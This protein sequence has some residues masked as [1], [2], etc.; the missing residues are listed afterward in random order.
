MR[1]DATYTASQA[2]T[3]GR[4]RQS[5]A[6][7]EQELHDI[8][9][10]HPQCTLNDAEE[11]VIP[12]DAL[13]DVLR[14][15]SS[16]HNSVEL[17]DKAEEE[18]LTAI[19][20]S[21]PGLQ[22]TPQILLQFIATKTGDS[23]AFTSSSS[24]NDSPSESALDTDEDERGRQ[25]ERD[26]EGMNSRSSSR[27]STATYYRSSSR[28]PK[29]PRD[30][31]F[32]T[33]RRQ[34]TTPLGKKETAPSSWSRRPAPPSR[35]KSD[36]SQGHGRA[37]SDSESISSPPPHQTPG[38]TRAPSNPT[39]PTFTS[40]QLSNSI[41]SPTFSATH[42][43]P[44]S[45]AQSQP[46]NT[47]TSFDHSFGY[48]SSPERDTG[49]TGLM[50]PP[51]SA[52]DSF[53]DD[54]SFEDQ[55]SSLQMPKRDD[56]DDDDEDDDDEINAHLL[57]LIMDRSAASSTASLDV[58]ERMEA[59]Q[60]LN[61]D[62]GRKLLEG[63]RT[64]QTR[65]SDHETELEEMQGRIEELRAELSATKRE[66]KELRS[67]ERQNATQIV[68][69][70]VEL[71]RTQKNL[72]QTRATFN[73]VQKQYSEQCAESERIRNQ[74]RL[75]D[76]DIKD[77]QEA[78][79]IQGVEAQK[80]MREQAT[81]EERI[82]LLESD[83]AIAL[84]AQAQLDEQKNENMLLK[85]TIDRM[86]FDMDELRNMAHSDKGGGSGT[87]SAHGSVSKSLGMEL[88]NKM[89]DGKWELEEEDTDSEPSIE[90][91]GTPEEDDT[92]SE[93]FVQTIITR[94]KRKVASRAKHIETLKID[95]MKEY[96]DTG[97]QHNPAEFTTSLSIQTVPPPRVFAASVQTQATLLTTMSIQTD[98]EPIPTPPVIITVEREIQT[99]AWQP[100]PLGSQAS[101]EDD[102][103]L[104]SSSSTLL[105][106]TPKSQSEHLHPHSHDL[107][108]A[109]DKV[110]SEDIALRISD[111]TLKSWHKGIQ[112]PI[113]PLAGGISADAVEDWKAIKEELGV[114]CAAIDKLIEESARNGPRPSRD[115]SKGRR[116]S[117]RFYNIYNTYVYGDSEGRGWGQIAICVG[118]S[119]VV[120][121]LMGQ[122]SVPQMVPGGVTYYDR[123]AWASYNA[124]PG[125]GEGI[126]VDSTAAV[127]S[128][129]GRLGGDAAR[130]LAGWPT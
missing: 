70:E 62:L 112:F 41:G 107:P 48:G 46:H 80:W 115:G 38:R 51:E 49:R 101:D 44:H 35:R 4:N 81:Y 16:N 114:E 102:E 97:T 75:R 78:A 126:T 121:F 15:F 87:A 103:T 120:A 85:E 19:L 91:E 1:Y 12:G 111:E 125:G 42:S 37:M 27:D 53:E 58:Q 129:L 34:R 122:A 76:Q 95:E 116:K 10:D 21:T 3:Y 123:A 39:S 56:D 88:L 94:T 82:Q 17:M 86:R 130:T 59:L 72:E 71:T 50:S 73:G 100:E 32:E 98:P 55:I 31:V 25:E 57:G 113:E 14:T 67:K 65:L 30:S 6:D 47:Y 60:R 7:L 45:R 109:Y 29:T 22:V 124:M 18:Q 108:P 66:E 64:L 43:R 83:L 92:E 79:H 52:D 33:G 5:I 96:S 24:S 20:S 26:H 61:T 127:W 99:E 68:A 8:F 104:A 63:E 2:E 23:G 119:A 117:G 69:L 28:G 93:D 118:A 54:R 105:P 11:P 9:T 13:V 90:I 74:L 84:Q 40:A 89:K 128:F 106:P 110:T 36:A 77:L